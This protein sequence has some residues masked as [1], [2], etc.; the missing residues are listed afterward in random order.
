MIAS[1]ASAATVYVVGQCV[2]STSVFGFN[3]PAPNPTISGTFFCPTAA[4]LG[5]G[6]TT[7]TTEFLVYNSDFSNGLSPAIVET[8]NY[9]IS[10]GA[11]T[12]AVTSDTLT[13]TGNA[14]IGSTSAV[15]SSGLTYNNFTNIPPIILSGCYDNATGGTLGGAVTVGYTN[16]FPTGNALQGTGYAEIVYDYSTGTPEPVSMIL[17]GSGLL[18][19][20]L[21]GRK[22]FARK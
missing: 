2:T 4:S 8:T 12:F 21:I 20:S 13:S 18:A 11:T 19:V 7:I 15:C 3:N 14:N 17:L 10:G 5:L 9:T 1:S 16:A 6:S 22:K